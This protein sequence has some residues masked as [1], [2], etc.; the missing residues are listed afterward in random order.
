MNGTENFVHDVGKEF[1]K[2]VYADGG[3]PIVKPTGE[4]IGLVP[5]A[6]KAA[7]EPLEKWILQREYN[8]EE[9]KKLLEEKLKNVPP[10]LIQPPEAFTAVPAFQYISYCMDSRELRDMYAN[11]LANS[12]N[13]L[14]KEGVH[15]SF[16]EIIKQ[17]V[18]DEAKILRYI[19]THNPNEI[20]TID[21]K[22]RN[23]NNVNIDVIRN[24]SNIGELSN[25][26]YPLDIC[27][28]IDNFARLGLIIHSPALSRLAELSLYEPLEKHSYIQ[29]KINSAAKNAEGFTRA[30]IEKKYISMTE[31]GK[32][33][34]KICLSLE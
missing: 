22:Y 8:I 17:L 30:S 23:E 5:R 15:P 1:T 32:K 19:Y 33:F 2:D 7:L 26:E 29:E 9:T 18:P 24:F 16:V 27:S 6:I 31:Y 3:K 28:Y 11:L 10:E 25:C 13:V 21:L 34:C 4:L 14:T 12:M 20:P